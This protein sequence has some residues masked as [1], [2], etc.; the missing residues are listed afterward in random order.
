MEVRNA[1]GRKDSRAAEGEQ[2]AV[3]G[4]LFAMLKYL[5]SLKL[6]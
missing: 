4:Y 3:L 5:V 1:T 2:P 6:R